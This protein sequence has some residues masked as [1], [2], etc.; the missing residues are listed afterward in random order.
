[1]MIYSLCFII[2][3]IVF[4][5]H[6]KIFSVL[7]VF[8]YP[9]NNRKIHKQPISLSGSIFLIINITI[10]L[11]Y[12][13]FFNN[14]NYL[15]LFKK[16]REFFFLLFALYGLY[17][18][19]YLDDKYNINPWTKLVATSFFLI[20]V[21]LADSLL[22]IE[23]LYFKFSDSVT[24]IT[25][26]NLSIFFTL[27]CFLA[28]LNAIN[29]FDGINLQIGGYSLILSLYLIVNNIFTELNIILI[30][31]LVPFLI[32]N[33]K[34]KVFIGNSGAT[35]I[36]FIYGYQYIKG[37]NIGF[38]EIDQILILNYFIGLDLL[39]VFVL[40]VVSGKSPLSADNNHI[41]HLLIKKFNYFHTILIN[42]F[43]ILAPVLL[44]RIFENNWIIL[45][46]FIMLYFSLIFY[47]K[48]L[49]KSIK[50]D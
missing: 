25:L 47:L 49:N 50:S 2:S 6:E 10:F 14:D 30:I 34:N 12:L 19:G 16:K 17:G 42:F 8:D 21:M 28:Y 40:R 1:M 44:S 35:I 24:Q 41:H 45:Y 48:I 20:S 27:I 26:D 33:F 32:L 39:R 31:S 13:F 11:I 5:F 15:D 43:M 37:Y 4:L 36:A 18:I 7:K 22:I 3:I 46:I 9:D 38:I 29:M 23:I